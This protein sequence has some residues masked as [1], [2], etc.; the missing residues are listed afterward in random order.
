MEEEKTEIAEKKLSSKLSSKPSALD[1]EIFSRFLGL[2][3]MKMDIP[4]DVFEYVSMNSNKIS[5]VDTHVI[6]KMI[7]GSSY[8]KDAV[9]RQMVKSLI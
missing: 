6:I 9:L 3:L 5:D 7:L 1:I 2:W 8:Q 4:Q